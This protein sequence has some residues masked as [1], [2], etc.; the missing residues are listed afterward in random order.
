MSPVANCL[1]VK[2]YLTALDDQAFGAATDVVPKFVS[3][4]YLSA[5]WTGAHGGQAFFSYS[6]NYLIDVDNAI[7]VDVEA[8]TAIRQTEVLAAKRMIERSI[9]RFDLYPARL[10]GD[11]AYGS[12]EMLGWLVY[13]HGIEPH[14][15]VFDKSTCRDGTFSRDDFTYYHAGPERHSRC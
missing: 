8:T 1:A 12:A 13:E 4:S 6:T 2:E 9:D 3:P 11:S 10:L 5:R 15:T 7:I 14:V